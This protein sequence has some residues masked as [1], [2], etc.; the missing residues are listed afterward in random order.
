[1]SLEKDLVSLHWQGIPGFPYPKDPFPQLSDINQSLNNKPFFVFFGS[2]DLSAITRIQ[3]S[4]YTIDYLNTHGLNIVLY[5]PLSSKIAQTE[6]MFGFFSEF[7]N[8]VDP[9]DLR[10]EELDCIEQYVKLNKLTN[11]IVHT[12]DYNVKDTYPYYKDYFELIVNDFFVKQLKFSNELP[13]S[14]T[15]SK[16]FIVPNWRYSKHRHLVTSYIAQDP[17][18]YSWYYKCSF[19]TLKDCTWFNLETLNNA[20][21]YN[22]I[23][24]GVEYLNSKT[25][26]CLDIEKS[27]HTEITQSNA[28]YWPNNDDSVTN[29][30]RLHH[31]TNSID[32]FYKNSFCALV[33][34]T[35]FA[36]PTGNFSEKVL[37]AVKYK[38]PFILV[39]P[40][41]TL[42]YFRSFGFKTFDSFW[43]EEYD[44]IEN[45]EHRLLEI[46]KLINNINNKSLSELEI[47]YSKMQP[48]L[49]YNF[50]LLIK[51]FS[52][53]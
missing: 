13:N 26:F 53:Q 14:K 10:A 31:I 48:I 7:K 11:V 44:S 36:Q 6:Y 8:T 3:H 38:T 9:I 4:K 23:K 32:F 51:K 21:V 12:C 50:Q 37:M 17:S 19:D 27:S 52:L 20:A 33:N 5:E 46:F 22:K 47:L 41:K 45:H 43:S 1:M 40:P 35:R 24:S 42:E 34:E 25:P 2:F 30:A 28:S 18:Y 29:P 16:K 49:D 15:I 39:A